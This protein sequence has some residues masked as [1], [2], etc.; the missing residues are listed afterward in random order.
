MNH[1]T[2]LDMILGMGGNRLSRRMFGSRILCNIVLWIIRA[3]I[4]ATTIDFTVRALFSESSR[5]KPILVRLYVVIGMPTGALVM[6]L[7]AYRSKQI[8]ILLGQVSNSSSKGRR[9]WLPIF[10]VVFLTT[11]IICKSMLQFFI[12]RL[13]KDARESLWDTLIV[14]PYH[15]NDYRLLYPLFYTIMVDLFSDYEV[16]ALHQMTQQVTSTVASDQLKLMSDLKNLKA[17][18]DK[19]EQLF[20]IIPFIMFA[21][22]FLTIPFTITDMA[23]KASFG[24][25]TLVN[26]Y[27]IIENICNALVIILVMY[28]SCNSREKVRNVIENMIETIQKRDICYPLSSSSQ[29]VIE[30]LKSYADF[31]FTGWYLFKIDR[32]LILTFLSALISFSVLLLQLGSSP[33]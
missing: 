15:M 16:H 26:V 8:A 12:S 2:Y 29:V 31:S 28:V 3:A 6:A 9:K 17:T 21:F 24:F 33:A 5:P 30:S 32:S 11:A 4:T 1:S 19:F 7:Y 10:S 14:L 20:S 25:S 27:Y 18:R 13:N 22:A 23:R